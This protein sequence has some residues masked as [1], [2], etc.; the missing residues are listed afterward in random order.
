MKLTKMSSIGGL[1]CLLLTPLAYSVEVT[2][3]SDADREN[4]WQATELTGLEVTDGS[5]FVVGSIADVEFD[6]NLEPRAYYLSV[7]G[8]L[9]VGDTVLRV[10]VEAVNIRQ[11][12]EGDLQAHMSLQDI[13]SL[14]QHDEDLAN[15]LAERRDEMRDNSAMG[16]REDYSSG[17]MRENNRNIMGTR[18]TSGMDAQRER[19]TANNSST[20]GQQNRTTTGQAATTGQTGTQSR[21]QDGMNRSTTTQSGN[22]QYRQPDANRSSQSG[23]MQNQN[24]GDQADT[25]TV[26]ESRDRAG[27]RKGNLTPAQ[28]GEVEQLDP[29]IQRKLANMTEDTRNFF[30]TTWRN[31]TGQNQGEGAEELA[32]LEIEMTESEVRISGEVSSAEVRD[33]ILAAARS[34]TDKRVIHDI[35]IEGS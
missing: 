6:Q 14:A 32:D 4:A 10:P 27:S 25:G 31:L 21:Q 22:Q 3:V 9:G 29:E 30:V 28:A 7:G 26:Y 23:A 18:N 15:G 11:G 13:E 12:T 1:T 20:Y 24:R 2:V 8:V 35:T 34:S 19:T 33:R 5:D 17:D 16:E